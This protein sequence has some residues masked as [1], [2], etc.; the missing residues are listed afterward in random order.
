VIEGEAPSNIPII[1]HTDWPYIFDW[2]ELKRWNIKESDLPPGSIVRYKKLSF[3]ELYR[4][5]II[6]VVSFCLIESLLI[7][8]LLAQRTKRRLAEHA[9]KESHNKLE[10]RVEEKSAAEIKLNEAEKRYRTIADFTYDWET[11]ES[12][13]RRMEYVSPSCERISGHRPQAFIDDPGLMQ[14]IILLDDRDR[15]DEHQ[16]NAMKSSSA[17]EIQFRIRKKDGEIRW[18]EHACQPVHDVDGKFLGVRASNRDITRRK[19][20]EETLQAKDKMLEEAQNI[21]RLGSW[22]WNIIKNE[23]AWSDEV[24]RIFGLS[25]QEFG[26]TYEAFLERIHPHDR[27]NVKDAVNRALADPSADYNIMHRIITPEGI[28]CVARERGNVTFDDKGKA[29]RMIGTVQDITD[30]KIMEAETQKLRSE[31]AHMDRSGMMGVLTAGIAHEI[32]QPLAAILSNAQ[33]A[34]RFLTGDRPDLDEVR[35][36][37]KDIISDD[38]RAGEIV[39]S[40]RNIMGRS[41]LKKEEFDFNETVREVLILIKSVVIIRKIFLSENLQPDIPKIYGHHIQIQQVILNLLMNALDALDANRGT[42][43]EIVISSRVEE[44]QGVVL[45]VSDSGPGIK[46]D[47]LVSIFDSFHTTKAGGMGVGLSIC[48][49]IIEDHGG[50]IWAGNRPEGGAVFFFKLPFGENRDE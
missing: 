30:I 12:P 43:S 22:D 46:P 9:L 28:E 49:S 36:A 16:T 4:W 17:Q 44:N 31:L 8:V 13:E 2:R 10:Q 14:E 18:I 32:N 5:Q 23:L 47:L 37:L 1:K 34:L 40:I 29:T 41:E 7:F 39:H 15:W 48:R 6:A 21:A 25:P 11:W 3:W 33:A 20:T 27:K 50:T 35:E 38:K 19:L 42:T 45:S 24:Y 26:A